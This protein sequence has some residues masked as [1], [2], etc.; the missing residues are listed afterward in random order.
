MKNAYVV[1]TRKFTYD[2]N[3][4][5]SDWQELNGKDV[6]PSD[7]EIMELITEW[8]YEDMRSPI[9]NAIDFG[10]TWTDEHGNPITPPDNL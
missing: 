5:V 8:M 4:I 7:D 2:V 10:I 3:Q 9:E 6:T 1:V